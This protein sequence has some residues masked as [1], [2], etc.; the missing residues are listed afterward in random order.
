[1]ADTYALPQPF[2]ELDHTADVGIR[3]YGSTEQE[4]LARLVL[5]F[6]AL[7][8]GGATELD[9]DSTRALEVAADEHLAMAVD[10]LRELLFV[11]DTEHRLPATCTVHTFDERHGVSLELAMAPVDDQSHEDITD[12]KAVTWH[13]ASFGPLS[14]GWSAQIIFD[15]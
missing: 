4:C 15:V 9:A 2:E 11:F 10:V 6:T 13:E 7:T 14:D 5:G 3:V 12:L 8:L 1:M